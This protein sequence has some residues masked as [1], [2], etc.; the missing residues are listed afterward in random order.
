MDT[1]LGEVPPRMWSRKKPLEAYRGCLVF[2]AITTVAGTQATIVGVVLGVQP[3]TAQPS[4]LAG[5]VAVSESL[6]GSVSGNLEHV[7][8]VKP[9][10]VVGQVHSAW[11]TGS[12][13]VAAS[14]VS[15][16][17]WAGMPVTVTVTLRPLA[18]FRAS[19]EV[20]L[21]AFTARRARLQAVE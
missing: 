7:E 12:A 3:T 15:V 8:V 6:L 19:S 1:P 9:G 10:T 20:V 18:R 4:E 21:R 5:V 17:G 11:T 13:A 16:T 14:G 2:S